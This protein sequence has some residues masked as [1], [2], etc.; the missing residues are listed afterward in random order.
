MTKILV[1]DDDRDS[2]DSLGALFEAMGHEVQVGYSGQHALSLA[3]ARVPHIIFLDLMM[4]VVDGFEAARQIRSASP[5]TDHPFIVALTGLSGAEVQKRTRE[6]GMDAYV[7]K[8][9]D[10]SALMMIVD[11]LKN[12]EHPSQPD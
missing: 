7:V 12:R 2:A 8:P 9:V 10:F 3:A 4:P 1:V 11:S 6:A 5:I